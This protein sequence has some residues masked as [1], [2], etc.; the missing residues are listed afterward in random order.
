MSNLYNLEPQPTAK[1]LL[2]TTAGDILLELFAKQTPLASRNFLQHCLDGYYD[3]TIFHRV[4]PKFIVQGGDPTGTGFGGDSI[5]EDGGPFAD[6]FHSRLKYNRRGLLGMA[7]SGKLNDNGSQFFITLGETPELA[8]KN[9][10]FGRVAGDTIFNVVK[11][12]EA[13]MAEQGGDRPLYPDKVIGAEILVNPF[14][15]MVKRERII[16]VKELTQDKPAKKKPKRKAGKVLLSFGEDGD[17]DGVA[18]PAVK[19]PKFNPKL[20]SGSET[21]SLEKSTSNGSKPNKKLEKIPQK[22]ELSINKPTT[23]EEIPIKSSN[24][25]KPRSASAASSY[26]SPSPP[27]QSTS[28]QDQLNKAQSEIDSLKATLRRGGAAPETVK[29]KPKSALE[30]MI[31]STSTRAR[32]RGGAHSTST[33]EEARTLAFFKAFKSKLEVV[34][35]IDNKPS[36]PD[37]P[38]LQDSAEKPSNTATTE[39]GDEEAALCDLHFIANCQSCSNWTT[40][41]QEE[42]NAGEGWMGHTLSFAKDRL[43]KDLEWKRK[44]EEEL[45]VIDPLEKARELGIERVAKS[46]DKKKRRDWDRGREEKST[47]SR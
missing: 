1:V 39:D 10:M 32:K 41:G 30:A 42:D 40:H 9:T 46:N 4:V 34:D 19:K 17:E 5:F 16:K 12:G 18:L 29:E 6:E 7:N 23:A 15:D 38:T 3:D 14:E 28:R 43:G 2:Q 11:M 25:P 20:V 36:T 44:N 37:E 21:L 22:V 24:P 47:K 31:P 26:S 27:P 8:G 45:V 33:I 13:E 35:D